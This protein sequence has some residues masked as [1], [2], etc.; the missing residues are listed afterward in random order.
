MQVSKVV[1]EEVKY[2]KM[3]KDGYIDSIFSPTYERAVKQAKGDQPANRP[4]KIIKVTSV[5]E[6]VGDEIK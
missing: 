3:D 1:K 4:Y 6:V 5:Y 2:T